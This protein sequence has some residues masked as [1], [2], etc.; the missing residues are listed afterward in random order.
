MPRPRKP[1]RSA[2]PLDETQRQIADAEH[3]LQAQIMALQREI[4]EAPV[5]AEQ[6]KR[7]RRAALV[8]SAKRERTNRPRAAGNQRSG[9]RLTPMLKAER[10]EQRLKTLA[11]LVLL[12]AIVGWLAVTYLF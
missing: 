12:L 11:L 8:E 5:R 1:T 6:E 10:R 7:E 9:R 4:E 3:K 2:S